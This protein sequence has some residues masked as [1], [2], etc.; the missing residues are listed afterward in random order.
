MNRRRRTWQ[1]LSIGILQDLS[2]FPAVKTS[3]DAENRCRRHHIHWIVKS[4]KDLRCLWDRRRPDITVRILREIV[5]R[6]VY[7]DVADLLERAINID[8]VYFDAAYP[9]ARDVESFIAATKQSVGELPAFRK[10][11]AVVARAVADIALCDEWREGVFLLR[12][13]R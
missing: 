12:I 3:P 8:F 4:R 7:V 11:A 10:D 6:V 2:D 9:R 13:S 1:H 5:E